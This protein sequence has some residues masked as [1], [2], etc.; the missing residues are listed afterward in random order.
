MRYVFFFI[1]CKY[2]TIDIVKKLKSLKPF[3]KSLKC[4]IRICS[5]L[6][7]GQFGVFYKYLISSCT[8]YRF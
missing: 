2:Y 6:K 1:F 5:I 4:V 3:L 8:E 7:T